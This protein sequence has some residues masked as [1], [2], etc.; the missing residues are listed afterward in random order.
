[1]IGGRALGSFERLRREV[2]RSFGQSARVNSSLREAIA[3]ATTVPHSLLL[4]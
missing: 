2:R 4:V 3:L 1:M